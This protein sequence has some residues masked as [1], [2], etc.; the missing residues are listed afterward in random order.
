MSL[1][2]LCESNIMNSANFGRYEV[3]R[4]VVF[5]PSK[6]SNHVVYRLLCE[7]GISDIIVSVTYNISS[8]A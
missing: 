1:Q 5:P 8:V 6:T 2:W 7:W 4:E 3:S